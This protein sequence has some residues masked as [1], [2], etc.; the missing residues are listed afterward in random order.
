MKIVAFYFGLN[1]SE[2]R[3]YGP[4]DNATVTYMSPSWIL[5]GG[6]E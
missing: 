3:F 1:F 6:L 2:D 4:L 5:S